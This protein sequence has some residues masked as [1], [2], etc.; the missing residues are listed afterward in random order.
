[1]APLRCDQVTNINA[2]KGNP[3]KLMK[4]TFTTAAL[5]LLSGNVL[6]GQYINTYGNFE[7]RLDTRTF[8][9]EAVSSKQEAYKLGLQQLHELDN[10][11]TQ[12]LNHK[13]LVTSDSSNDI[14]LNKNGYVTVQEFMNDAGQILYK[15]EV[16]VSYHYAERRDD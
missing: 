5:I 2:T 8:H 13:L 9:T 7:E 16:N 10:S 15:G 12:E 11:S 3:M 14:H 1:M 4:T 6:A